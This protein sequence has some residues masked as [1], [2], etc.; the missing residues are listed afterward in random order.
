MNPKIQV[1]PIAFVA[2]Q[3]SENP[4]SKVLDTEEREKQSPEPPKPKVEKKQEEKNQKKR[5]LKRSL[6]RKK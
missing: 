4:G 3:T 2:K 6:K 1:V 5:K